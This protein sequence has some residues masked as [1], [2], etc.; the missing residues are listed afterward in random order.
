MYLIEIDGA[1][2]F[3]CKC[4]CIEFLISGPKQKH[5]HVFIFSCRDGVCE[6]AHRI[7]RGF[8]TSGPKLFSR[9]NSPRNSCWPP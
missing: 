5:V 2:N 1:Q 6:R 4:M 9:E 8:A 7:E 3:S